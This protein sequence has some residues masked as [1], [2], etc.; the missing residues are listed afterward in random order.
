MKRYGLLLLLAMPLAAQF[1]MPA[2]P[3]DITEII[4]QFSEPII[5]WGEVG[6]RYGNGLFALLATI[7][8][9]VA[10]IKLQLQEPDISMRA[11]VIVRTTLTI[12]A[13]YGLLIL[14][15]GL[16]QLII[17]GYVRIGQVA[18]GVPAISPGDIMVDGIEI[19]GTLLI[20]GAAQGVGLSIMTALVMFACAGMVLAAFIYLVK[21]FVMALI[22]S[23]FTIYVAV[24]QL[25]WGGSPYTSVY[26]ERYVAAAMAVGI[27]LMTFYF[28]VG[29]ERN[30]QPFWLKQA[31]GIMSFWGA[32]FYALSLACSIVIFCAIANPEKLGE[33]LFGGAPN[34]TG[35]D[36]NAHVPWVRG[37]VSMATTGIGMAAG[38][39][40]A[41]FA[42]AAVSGFSM[43]GRAA[44]GM[45]GGMNGAATGPGSG[46]AAT[47]PQ[48][49]PPPRIPT[50]RP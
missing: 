17:N 38:Y 41:G 49:A 20:V 31:A 24:I 21:G 46:F 18:S 35:H 47:P 48:P 50:P 45:P 6:L 44:G 22:Q 14:G 9:A 29:V 26:A 34:F 3:P 15:P 19:A 8:M 5:N 28:I 42:P 25:A 36:L 1:Q 43:A 16:M 30:M 27:K 23:Y 12:G 4:R 7:T 11:A 32:I 13:F 33:L 40:S 37:A 39:A 10:L 2:P